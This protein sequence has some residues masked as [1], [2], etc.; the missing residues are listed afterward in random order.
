[1]CRRTGEGK[2]SSLS[3]EGYEYTSVGAYF[4]TLNTHRRESLFGEV[5]DGDIKLSPFGDVVKTEWLASA[6]IRREIQLHED[7]FVVMPNHV[8]GIVW[9]V[10][11]EGAS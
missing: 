2:R 3:L 4:I 6:S 10:P 9:V 11:E 7:E 5:I 8:H 1:M